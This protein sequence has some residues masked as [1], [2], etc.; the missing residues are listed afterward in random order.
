MNL[1]KLFLLPDDFEKKSP[2]NVILSVA[3]ENLENKKENPI[4][5]TSDNSLQLK[6]N[7]FMIGTISLMTT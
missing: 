3:L 2:D 4:I 7:I 5:L 6:S 1:P